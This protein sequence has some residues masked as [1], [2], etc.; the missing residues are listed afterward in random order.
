MQRREDGARRNDGDDGDAQ[1]GS[2]Q[3]SVQ[4]A[5]CTAGSVDCRSL[6]W[7]V[8]AL[9]CPKAAANVCSPLLG[10]LETAVLGRVDA[11]HLAAIGVANGAFSTIF[12][13][14]GFLR[15]GSSGLIAQV[16]E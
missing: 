14:C 15:M 4:A 16:Y 7:Q 3:H 2:R 12:G 11:T 5:E 6:H 10:A 8:L 13:L 1:Q 9:S